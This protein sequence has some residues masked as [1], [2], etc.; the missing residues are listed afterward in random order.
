[1]EKEERKKHI[2]TI[3]DPSVVGIK[4]NVDITPNDWM[5]R[6]HDIANQL[7]LPKFKLNNEDDK[8]LNK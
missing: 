5:T 3:V 1:M 4:S 8:Q 6:E 7:M 2:Q